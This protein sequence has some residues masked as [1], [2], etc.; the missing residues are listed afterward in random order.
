M[1]HVFRSSLFFT[2]IA[3]FSASALAE[4]P[5]LQPGLWA[6]T[7]NTSIEGPMN[8]PPQTNS[9]Q[10]CLTQEKLD[11]GIDVLNIHESCNV[12]QA[13]I[14]RDRVDYAASCNMEGMTMMFKGYANFHGNRLEGKMTSDMNSP[15]GP[16][17]MKTDYQGERIGE[18]SP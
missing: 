9:N 15:L 6:Y 13:D 11:K 7:S 3:L 18:C 12:T 14:K 8:I 16:M 5:N 4:T 2:G 17:V 10:E 1:Q